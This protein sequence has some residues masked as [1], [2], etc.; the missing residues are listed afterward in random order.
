MQAGCFSYSTF[1]CFYLHA[2]LYPSPSKGF[3]LECLM[4]S[5]K[6]L[7]IASSSSCLRFNQSIHFFLKSFSCFCNDCIQC[8]IELEQFE[9]PTALNS[10]L[11]PVKANM[12]YFYL[13][14]LKERLN[15]TYVNFKSVFSSGDNFLP[16]RLLTQ[17]KP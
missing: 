13:Y 17:L 8:S 14:C 9:L 10:N 7:K 4:Y 1:S 3:F 11:F 2:S 12:F 6:T 15:F 5:L 16:L